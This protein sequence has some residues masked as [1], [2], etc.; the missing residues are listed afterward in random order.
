[1]FNIEEIS[2]NN[3]NNNATFSGQEL[4]LNPFHLCYIFDYVF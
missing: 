3:L 4:H 1:M 2:K